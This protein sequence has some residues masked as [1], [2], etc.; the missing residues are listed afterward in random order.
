MKTKIIAVLLVA[1]MVSA[2]GVFG[3]NLDNDKVTA[4]SGQISLSNRFYTTLVDG[5]KE[6][7]LMIP[8]WFRLKDGENVEVKGYYMND[9]FNCRLYDAT[10]TNIEAFFVTEITVD[11][12]TYPLERGY[13]RGG[14]NG[15][16]RGQGKGCGGGGCGR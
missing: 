1:L 7:A 14:C 16:G 2:T 5:E 3:F 8:R 9:E 13:G 15:K 12:E 11:G 10:A 4:I 6:I